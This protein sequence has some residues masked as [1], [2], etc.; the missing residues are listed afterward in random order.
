MI[1]IGS[2]RAGEIYAG[3]NSITK[4]YNGET[5]IFLE[6]FVVGLAFNEAG[7]I[8][9]SMRTGYKQADPNTTAF[10][11]FVEWGDGVVERVDGEQHAITVGGVTRY[12]Y[13][14]TIQHNYDPGDYMLKINKPGDD[15]LSITSVSN[16]NG[17]KE[18]VTLFDARAGRW[19]I[20]YF[21]ETPTSTA[22]RLRTVHMGKNG[23]QDGGF[24]NCPVLETVTMEAD[25]TIG[26]IAFDGC[27]QL[28]NVEIRAKSV[29]IYAFRNCPRMEKAWMR[30]TVE[31][32]GDDIFLNNAG[33]TVYCEPAERPS[34][35]NTLW[36]ERA[37][38]SY[39]PTIWGQAT[40]PW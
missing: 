25:A 33:L 4:I 26:T 22:T 30:N 6:Q 10:P 2:S 37:S 18:N 9:I 32:A 19:G 7:N 12:R 23:V 36:N 40:R 17:S 5:L 28:N 27:L 3:D 35:W 15:I 34:G 1:E 16:G 20:P 31:A 13:T 29:S 11:I 39:V 24:M 21:G 14:A 38:G 8:S